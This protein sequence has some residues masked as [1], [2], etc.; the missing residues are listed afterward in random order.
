MNAPTPQKPESVTDWHQWVSALAGPVLFAVYFTAVYMFGEFY[1]RIGLFDFTIGGMSSVALGTLLSTVVTLGLMTYAG[2]VSF[3]VWWRT[4]DK[5]LPEWERE[6]EA[7]RARFLGL[8]GMVT[9]GIFF[10]VTIG[11]AVA[12]FA[13]RPC[14]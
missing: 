2:F 4:G 9:N 5:D 13:L 10:V 1:C 3:R 14:F 11:V 8:A 6:E 7:D 12:A